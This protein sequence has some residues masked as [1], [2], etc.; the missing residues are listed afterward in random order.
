MENLNIDKLIEDLC[1]VN[2]QYD[3][4]DIERLEKEFNCEISCST[5]KHNAL[6]LTYF[7]EV[8]FGK[9]ENFFI[10]IES[11]INNGTQVNNAEW[12]NNTF[13]KTKIIEV[14]KDFV[15]DM[16]FY[17]KGSFM[18]KKAQ[19]V[20]DANKSKLFE[21]HRKNNYDNYVTGGNS[22]MKLDPLLSQLRLINV[23]EEQEV[24]CNIL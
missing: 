19:A 8:D 21:F 5:E 9:E 12:G 1:Y 4:A 14:L 6:Q 10:E 24:Y 11:G 3:K 16:D 2:P 17:E 13:S 15:L 22:K 20:L 18:A 7:Y 23:Y